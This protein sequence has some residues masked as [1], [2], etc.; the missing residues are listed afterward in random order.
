[1]TSS[2]ILRHAWILYLPIA[3]VSILISVSTLFVDGYERDTDTL[4]ASFGAGMGIMTLALAIGPLRRGERWAALTLAYV[5]VF[6][7][8]HIVALGTWIPDGIFLVL[9]VLGLAPALAKGTE[10]VPS[11]AR[12]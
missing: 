3:A 9:S 5:P 12:A 10:R 1:M 11:T 2:R 8:W 4:I 6:F 7:A